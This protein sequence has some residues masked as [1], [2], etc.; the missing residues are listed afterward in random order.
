MLYNR[1]K[2]FCFILILSVVILG[3]ARGDSVRLP[4]T[5]LA[6]NDIHSQYR[7]EP[8]ELNLGGIARL[9][10]AIKQERAAAG[11]SVLIDGG[12]WSEGG[13]YYTLGAGFE[14]I[15]MMELLG[16]DYLAIGNH[17]YLNGP[18][19][20]LDG[21]KNA[22]R[23]IKFL[24]A[25]FDASAYSRAEEFNKLV[26]PYVVRRFGDIRVA[27]VGLTTYEIIFDKFIKPVT[28]VSPFV[29]LKSLVQKLK[30]ESDAIVAVSHNSL[31]FNK[32]L[33]RDVPE[34][35]FVVGAHDHKTVAKAIE[36]PRR[37][38]TPGYLMEAGCHARFLGKI[39]LSIGPRLADGTSD[40]KL[41]DYK[42]IQIDSRFEQDE[43]TFE[44]LRSLNA[45][46]EQKYGPIFDHVVGSTEVKLDRNGAENVIGNITVDA[47]RA[48]TG[49]DIGFDQVNLIYNGIDPGDVRS[50]DIY[51]AN[52]AIYNPTTGKSWTL[53]TFD[54][55]GRT[56]EW[57]VNLLYSS[58]ALAE[59]GILSASGM[60]LIYDP[61]L[62]HHEPPSLW[63]VL[64]VRPFGPGAT[65][66]LGTSSIIREIRIN[67]KPLNRSTT[68]H[69]AAGGGPVQTIEMLNEFFPGSAP[70]T[71]FR[72]TG[73]ENWK[74]LEQYFWRNSPITARNIDYGTRIRTVE[75]DLGVLNY[76]INAEPQTDQTGQIHTRLTATVHN[77]GASPY[78]AGTAAV[79]LLTLDN[80]SDLASELR[81]RVIGL[82]KTVPSLAPGESCTLVWDLDADLSGTL[83]PVAASIE[84]ATV[85]INSSNDLALRWFKF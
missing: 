78:K 47:Y 22:S 1:A 25:N 14:N 50:I 46:I 57:M 70:I 58:N 64:S 6:T 13:I 83:Y 27:F 37:S 29:P 48:F 41:T 65:P 63:D 74:V 82:P 84:G 40:F 66:G 3:Q 16:Y 12:D 38:K 24:A 23:R 77:Y 9:A 79:S 61:L 28:I 10:T 56:L 54:M 33:L 7:P 62:T 43:E 55:T 4:L 73:V 80:G 71:N 31:T 5:I 68:Y 2:L 21:I 49:A 51:N 11:D 36:V 8:D 76:D 34:I 20:M 35:D 19:V 52:P 15:R 69:V 26:V 32:G 67:G 18:D 60:Q 85:D 72:D 17:E 45:Q 42:L 59:V 44:R 75:P 53:K 39:Q 30:Q 81:P